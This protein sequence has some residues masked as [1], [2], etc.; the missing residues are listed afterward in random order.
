[1]ITYSSYHWLA[2]ALS[3][4]G[5]RHEKTDAPCQDANYW[6][7]LNDN[8]LVAG[9]ADGAGSAKQS[10]VGAN[11]AVRVAVE[12][13]YET[14][15]HSSEEVIDWRLVLSDALKSAQ[16]AIELEAITQN[17]ET[18]DLATTLILV[19]A[20]PDMVVAG[21]VGDGAVVIE[22]YKGNIIGLTKPNIGEHINETTFITATDAQDS[23]M[24]EEWH[25]T[26]AHIAV[27]SDGLQMLALNM[28]EG[29]PYIPFFSSLFRFLSGINSE[30][31]LEEQLSILLQSPRVRERA[32]DD[33]TLLLACLHHKI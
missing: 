22:D 26:V 31:K 15:L 4:T 11:L 3:S 28:P 7:I 18:R 8:I 10:E 24:I 17:I 30:Q 13:I 21:Q 6:K 9:I 27:F 12:T 14:L 19:V 1:M 29:I 33:L 25:G 5:V 23:L 2:R 16:K 32:D 20:S